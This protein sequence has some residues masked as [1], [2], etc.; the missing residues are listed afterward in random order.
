MQNTGHTTSLTSRAWRNVCRH[1]T[2]DLFRSAAMKRVGKDVGSAFCLRHDMQAAV[3]D[4][5][6]SPCTSLELFMRAVCRGR[7]WSAKAASERFRFDVM[8]IN[9]L[10]TIDRGGSTAAIVALV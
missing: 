10:V 5:L 8:P 2:L 3:D 9:P 1:I 4:F 6:G 7:S